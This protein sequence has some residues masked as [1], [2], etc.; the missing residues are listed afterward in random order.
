MGRSDWADKST[1]TNGTDWDLKIGWADRIWQIEFGR[2][3]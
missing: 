2:I 1:R 3:R